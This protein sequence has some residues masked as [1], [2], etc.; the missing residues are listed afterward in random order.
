MHPDKGDC[1]LGAQLAPNQTAAYPG[2]DN[3]LISVMV[4]GQKVQ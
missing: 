3:T 4:E 1:H 2:N